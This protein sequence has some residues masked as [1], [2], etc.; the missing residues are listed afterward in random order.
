VLSGIWHGAAWTFLLWGFAHGL[1]HIVEKAL[2]DLIPAK[3]PKSKGLSICLD[4]LRVF[5]TFV[6]VT[7]FWVIFRATDIEHLKMI[8]VTAFTKFDQGLMMNVKPGMWLYLGI[9][10]L[11]DILLRN[12]RFDAWCDNKPL[13]L[14]WLIYAVLVFMTICC[15]SVYNFPFIYF[16][17]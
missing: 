15:S 16:Q 8:F 14:R 6:L 1:L 7:L 12:T 3:E 2:H 17:F 9:L 11:F 10:I 4:A 13:A 5:K